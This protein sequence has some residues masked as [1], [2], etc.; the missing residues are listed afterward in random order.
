MTSNEF[1]A[2]WH[3]LEGLHSPNVEGAPKL[4]LCLKFGVIPTI[5]YKIGTHHFSL[6]GCHLESVGRTEPVFE[7]NL[8]PSEER[9]TYKFLSNSRTFFLS[10]YINV[11][12]YNLCAR[13]KVKGHRE[14]KIEENTSFG[15]LVKP[16]QIW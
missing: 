12:N 10:S 3:I 5:I 4:P 6:I 16:F 9:P 8:A 15:K 1:D 13:A 14:V 11:T 2:I 7:R